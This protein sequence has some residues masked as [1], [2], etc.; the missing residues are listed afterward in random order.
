[1]WL[2]S[3]LAKMIAILNFKSAHARRAPQNCNNNY[4]NMEEA[5]WLNVDAFMYFV[6]EM[7]KMLCLAT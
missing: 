5:W 2:A 1:M 4:I 7:N 6:E 3:M